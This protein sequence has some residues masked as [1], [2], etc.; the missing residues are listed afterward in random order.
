MYTITNQ[1]QSTVIAT[2]A[3]L[4]NT[5]WSRGRGLMGRRSLDAG[6]GLILY[7]NNNIHMFFM[8]FPIDVIFVDRTH[9]VV[10]VREHFRPWQP[11]AGARQARYTLELP[12]NTIAT[13]LT[14][15]GDTIAVD[16]AIPGLAPLE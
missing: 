14:Q 6:A 10:G 2:A 4:A 16:P 7:P 12:I 15:I 1:T 5:F 11:F 9:R 8:R 13:S 3:E